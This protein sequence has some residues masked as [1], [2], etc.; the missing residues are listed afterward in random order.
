MCV[1]V[2]VILRSLGL[3]KANVLV[4]LVILRF[5]QIEKSKCAFVLRD[6]VPFLRFFTY[7]MRR[8]PVYSRVP[9]YSVRTSFFF[10]K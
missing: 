10:L 8:V 3:R 4:V 5:L 1:I 2:L 7:H 6:Y 9:W